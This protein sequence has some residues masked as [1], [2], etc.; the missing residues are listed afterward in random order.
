MNGELCEDYEI[1]VNGRCLFNDLD[2]SDQNLHHKRLEQEV[3]NQYDSS[4]ADKEIVRHKY[5]YEPVRD[6][7][8]GD[9][10]YYPEDIVSD[11]FEDPP[12]SQYDN[13]FPMRA[14]LK[15]AFGVD[16]FEDASK[17]EDFLSEDEAE[18]LINGLMGSEADQMT[19]DE[20]DE[21]ANELPG[22]SIFTKS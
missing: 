15:N 8:Q 11:I 7:D 12:E 21:I 14:G 9:V 16:D 2:T 1:C 17:E 19:E 22:I 20:A 10:E 6:F 3:Y 18:E 5:S 13:K 4:E